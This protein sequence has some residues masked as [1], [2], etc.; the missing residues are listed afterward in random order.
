[1]KTV[2][3]INGEAVTLENVERKG[4]LLRFTLGKNTYHFRGRALQGGGFL[5]EEETASGDWLPLHATVSADKGVRRVQIGA[6][7]AKVSEAKSGASAS[8][9]SGA[10]SPPSPMPGIVRQILVKKGDKV[11]KGDALAV[12]E[13][14]KLQLTLAAGGDATVEAVLVKVGDLVTEGVE[15]I[16]LKEQK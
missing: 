5:L 12:M 6:C 7:E 8:G 15:L 10:L 1:M 9:A 11:K 16:K 4:H 14:M 13:A 3:H 2:L